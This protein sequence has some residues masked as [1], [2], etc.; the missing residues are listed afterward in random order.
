MNVDNYKKP[1]NILYFFLAFIEIV[2]E[3][4]EY[5]PLIYLLKPSIPIYLM[6]LYWITSN[7]KQGIFFLSLFFS[8]LTNILL[9][10]NSA[11]ML[12]YG[13]IAFSFFRFFSIIVIFRLVRIKNYLPIM[14]AMLPFLLISFYLFMET[15]IPENSFFI[16]VLQNILISVY[17]GIALASY[18][19]DDNK[20]NSI[21]LISALLFVVLQFIVFIE[22][23]FLNQEYITFL[24]PIVMTF[25]S[26]A[27]YSYYRYVIEAENSN[28]N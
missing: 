2:A 1:I 25:N 24:R 8:C 27:F 6:G 23:Y 7:S 4:F 3:Y 16:L 14:I 18:Y 13:I 11:T 12:F 5:K 28:N 20:Q 26:L 10:P 21:L 9:V 15:T 19:M 17:A 22:R